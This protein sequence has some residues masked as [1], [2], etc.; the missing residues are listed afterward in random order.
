M[1]KQLTILLLCTFI[2]PIGLLAQTKNNSS[3]LWNLYSFSGEARLNSYYRDQL[4]TGNRI[5]EKQKSS[6]VSAGILLR[7]QNYIWSPNFITLDLGGEYSPD[8]ANEKYLVI[9]DQAE[10]GDMRRFNAN[11]IFLPQNK[12]SIAS[13]FNYGR[14]YN[15]R[16]NLSSIKSTDKNWGSTLNYRTNKIPLSLGYISSNQ[17]A[18][19]IQ[20][21]RRYQSKQKNLE[22]RANASFGKSDKHDLVVS[23]NYYYR[24]D[25]GTSEAFNNIYN[26]NYNGF[27]YLGVNKKN[28]MSTLLSG[29]WQKG[30]ETFTRYQAV[31]RLNIEL[32]KDLKFGSEY[33]FFSDRRSLQT[34]NQ[35]RIGGNLQHQ[36]FE[37][38]N[39]QISYNYN[40]TKQSQYN[41]RLQG[42]FA[43]LVYTK[44][45]MKHHNLDISYQ[46]NLQAQKWNS[47]DGF[48]NVI[49]ESVTLKDG[50]ITLLVRPYINSSSIRVKDVTGTIF[51]QELLD[52]LLIIQNKFV[53]IQRIPGGLIP[54][55]ATIFIDYTAVQPGTYEF[56]SF[57]NELFAGLSF[58]NRLFSVYYRK[59]AQG[60][61]NLK[62]TD[63]VTL[64]YYDK[65]IIGAKIDYKFL[66]IGAEYDN[67]SSTI[68]PYQLYRY[69]INL[70][71]TLK[72]K[73]ILAVNGN[74]SDYKKLN[75]LKNVR[76]IDMYGSALYQFNSQLSLSGTLIYMDQKGEGVSL[77]LLS[78]RTEFIA[79]IH[80]LRFSA[81]YNNYNRTIFNEKIVFNS[82]NVQLTRKF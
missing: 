43:S 2:N 45:I 10:N 16:E 15:N 58:Y 30:N 9:P 39:S 47:Q 13:Y 81:S 28:S 38:L 6:F 12:F 63:F 46:Y 17:D 8:K 75:N 78:F 68:L 33:A 40:I 48:I 22:A 56:T 53:Q 42:G 61:S 66:S 50:Q 67:M 26:A 80:K 62:K 49:N 1:K 77:N 41:E 3:R 11:L 36:L 21:G 59:S 31:E 18:T 52:Y 20:T 54:D 51:Y 4:R 14:V 24:K 27:A 73:V 65:Q 19:E 60:Y 72:N 44:K 32:S 25:Y 5:S 57:N 74:L 79:N 29:A 35:H 34:V 7:T 70:Q 23:S 37:S 71:G 76:Y 69:F 82:V 55:N 64:N